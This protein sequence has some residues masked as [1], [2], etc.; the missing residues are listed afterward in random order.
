M[1]Q[2]H[3]YPGGKKRVLTFSYDDG[4]AEDERL[5][6][7]FNKYSVKATFHLNGHKYI[8]K[9]C[10]E[11]DE[12]K[13]LYEG[14]EVSCHTLMHG[15]PDR[16]PTQSLVGEIMEDR[17]ILEKLFG[18]PI[19]G[20]SYPFGSYDE[21]IIA[22]L[23]ACGIVYSRTTRSTRGFGTPSDFLMWHPT[24]HHIDAKPIVDSFL[25]NIDSVWVSPLLY[26][27]GHSYEFRTEEDWKYIENII[28]SLSG[29]EKIW[30]ATNIEIYNYITAQKNLQISADETVFYNPSS[31]DVWVEKD[32]NKVIEIP[33]GK[34]VRI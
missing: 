31:I 6:E 30:Y 12:I 18:Y 8:G 15:W 10:D 24:C 21:S 17:K 7:L 22:V 14:H 32:K 11:L 25:A 19:V 2:Y 27:W 33:A 28:S 3:V 1:I 13:E 9:N 34:T 4:N 16:M 23:R 5:I 26:I 29:N 20:M